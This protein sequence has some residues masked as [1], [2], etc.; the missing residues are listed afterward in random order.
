MEEDEDL[1]QYYRTPGS[2]TPQQ[3]T[4]SAPASGE[5]DDLAQ[6][7]RAK[8]QAFGF[9]KLPG[10]EGEGAPYVDPEIARN[11]E[12]IDTVK[13]VGASIG[14]RLPVGV[15]AGAVGLPGSLEQIGQ[16]AVPLAAEKST[17]FL[18]KQGFMSPAEQ[19]KYMAGI[20]RPGLL[21]FAAMG[22]QALLD[23]YVPSLGSALTEGREAGYVSRSGA[24]TYEGV[25]AAMK[26]VAPFLEY[27]SKTTPGEYS[28][29]GAETAGGFALGPAK[30]LLGRLFLGTSTGFGAKA[31]EKFAENQDFDPVTGK[32]LGTVSGFGAGALGLFGSRYLPGRTAPAKGDLAKTLDAY[33]V[34]STAAARRLSEGP[35]LQQIRDLTSQRTGTFLGSLTPEKT[36][37]TASAYQARIASETAD[38]TSRMYKLSMDHPEAQSISPKLFSDLEQ[39]PE[40]KKA[41]VQAEKDAAINPDFMI[42]VPRPATAK[43]VMNPNGQPFLDAS[44]NPVITQTP[45]VTGNLAF[46]NQVYKNLGRTIRA[47]KRADAP[48]DAVLTSATNAKEMLGKRLDAKVDVY[49]DARNAHIEAIGATNAVDAGYDFLKNMPELKQGPIVNSIKKMSP[50]QRE[51]FSYGILQNIQ[52]EIGKGNIGAVA[53]QMTMK[54]IYRERLELALGPEVFAQVRGKVLGENLIEQAAALQVSAAKTGARKVSDLAGAGIVAGLVG[55]GTEA[56]VAANQILMSTM[57]LAPGVGAKAAA[58]AAIGVGGK[59]LYNKAERAVAQ[60]M[61]PMITEGTPESLAKLSKLMDESRSAKIVYDKLYHVTGLLARQAS[62]G[63]EP[64]EQRAFGGRVGRANG[65]RVGVDVEADALVRA[66]DRAKKNFNRTTE[67]LLNTPDNHIAKALEAA[68]RAI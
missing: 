9:N 30:G 25:S 51:G 68:N 37:L 43:P 63:V 40:F 62:E 50:Q 58:G 7:Y 14:T 32:V 55:A 54:P 29:E 42:G 48:N 66:A 46:Y 67:P 13:D 52:D 24:P 15:V 8:P 28:G 12:M 16:M 26:K 53:K 11:R 20:N 10:Y 2:R 45:E 17:D 3:S 57:G 61:I 56:V 49:K 44:G 33:N 5:E 31:G 19:E 34:E 64:E 60:K 41:L 35:D 59:A 22:K 18:T 6:Y 4:P 1:Q 36:P 38:E 39:Y 21:D 65:G 23:K 47:E 27:K